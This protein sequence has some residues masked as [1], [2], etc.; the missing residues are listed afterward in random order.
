LRGF[1]PLFAGLH[2]KSN[3]TPEI[4]ALVWIIFQAALLPA[5]GEN[6]MNERG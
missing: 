6:V 5:F 4:T 2:D 3:G 1:L